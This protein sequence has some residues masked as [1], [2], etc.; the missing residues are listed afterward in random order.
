MV[1]MS[2]HRSHLHGWLPPWGWWLVMLLVGAQWL[3][4]PSAERHMRG[5]SPAA[6]VCRAS[7]NDSVNPSPRAVAVA[8]VSALP[9]DTSDS[10]PASHPT[11]CPQ[12][13][14]AGPGL[15][16]NGVA[17]APL[18]MPRAR[19]AAATGR[20]APAPEVP[21]PNARAPPVL[22]RLT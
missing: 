16:T 7:F 11:H 2:A 20:V 12:C 18:P 8:G 21:R 9:Q 3:M 13:L 19:P 10:V 1:H 22:T 4:A 6:S 17:W 5:P 15:P 14:T